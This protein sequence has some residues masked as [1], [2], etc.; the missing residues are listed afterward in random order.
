MNESYGNGYVPIIAQAIE[1]MKAEQ[2]TSFSLEQINLAE[3]ERRTGISR[4]KLRRLKKNGFRDD[5]RSDEVRKHKITKLTSYSEIIDARL[6]QGVSNSTVILK[7]L[8]ESGFDGTPDPLKAIIFD[9]GIPRFALPAAKKIVGAFAVLDYDKHA[10]AECLS[11]C[12]FYDHNAHHRR[13]RD[14]W[15]QRAK[16]A[17][18]PFAFQSKAPEMVKNRYKS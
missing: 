18:R 4:G 11:A 8:R 16:E 6:K 9:Y 15:S 17:T 13:F 1:E 7:R 2:G 3:L 10:K 12:F 14:T 5:R